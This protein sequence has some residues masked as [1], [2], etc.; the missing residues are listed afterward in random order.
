MKSALLDLKPGDRFGFAKK[1][2]R[3]EKIEPRGDYAFV[4]SVF[5]GAEK[6]IAE[7]IGAA[8]YVPC[9]VRWSKA[10]V[11]K[12][13]K[14][15]AR[16]K[17]LTFPLFGGYIFLQA[18]PMARGLAWLYNDRKFQRFLSFEGKPIAVRIREVERLKKLERSGAY[19]ETTKLFSGIVGSVVEVESGV[20]ADKSA[21]ILEILDDGKVLVEFAPGGLPVKISVSDLERIGQ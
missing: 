21:V 6:D 4:I 10:R 18:D 17:K 8:A 3:E 14:G 9:S 19:D 12:L 7:R 11:G 13:K 2:V 20:F 5:E 16:R 1:I 15:E